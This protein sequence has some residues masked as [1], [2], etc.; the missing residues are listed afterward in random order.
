[1]GCFFLAIHCDQFEFCRWIRVQPRCVLLASWLAVNNW[2]SSSRFFIQRWYTDMPNGVDTICLWYVLMILI[3]FYQNRNMN[4]PDMIQYAYNIPMITS[5]IYKPYTKHIEM[6][7]NQ[8][9][10]K[11][12]LGSWKIAEEHERSEDVFPSG[13]T[14][15]SFLLSST[16]N[17]GTCNSG[18]PSHPYYSRTIPIRIPWSMG[19]VWE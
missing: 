11:D 4:T 1:M 2:Q 12:S 8:W 3:I 10:L 19:M 16:K 18:T 9:C 6:S 14:L 17:P 13:K 5:M 7:T 15:F